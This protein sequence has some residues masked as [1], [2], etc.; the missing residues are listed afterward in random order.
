MICFHCKKELEGQEKRMVA[1]DRP[2]INLFFCFE[3]Y[4]LYVKSDTP[5]YL[6]KYGQSVVQ[7]KEN[8]NKNGRK[9]VKMQ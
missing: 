7:L 2:Y 8:E 1:L 9:R 5:A 3:C 6:V 4:T